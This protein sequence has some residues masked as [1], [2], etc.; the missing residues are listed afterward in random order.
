MVFDPAGDGVCTWVNGP[1]GST[2]SAPAVMSLYEPATG[3]SAQSTPLGGN[4]A[5]Y[6]TVFM[7]PN[8]RAFAA[9]S[10]GSATNVRKVR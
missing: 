8:G 7:S 6:N 1:N 9:W 5:N 10:E 2:P 3:W 4:V